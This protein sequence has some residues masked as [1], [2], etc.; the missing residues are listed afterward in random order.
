MIG[1]PK[2]DVQRGTV[3]TLFS[4]VCGCPVV[5]KDDMRATVSW[6]LIMVL[7]YSGHQGPGVTE[8]GEDSQ[9]VIDILT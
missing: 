7:A 5:W 9:S 3:S 4:D 1:L 2:I 6:T 8:L